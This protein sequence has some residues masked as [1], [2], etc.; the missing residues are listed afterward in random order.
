M[1][2]SLSRVYDQRTQHHADIDHVILINEKDDLTGFTMGDIVLELDG[3]LLTP[4]RTAGL[5]AGT[6]CDELLVQG[7]IRE[8]S[9]TIEDVNRARINLGS[10]T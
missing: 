5:L 3:S 10:A 4:P 6:Y 9:L 8:P 1:R 7:R 2:L